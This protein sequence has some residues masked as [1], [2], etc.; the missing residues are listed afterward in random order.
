[1]PLHALELLAGALMNGRVLRERTVV[2]YRPEQ[3]A[4]GSAVGETVGLTMDGV[5]RLGL[6]TLAEGKAQFAEWPAH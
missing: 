4:L 6:P 3:S 5:E 1:V 2:R